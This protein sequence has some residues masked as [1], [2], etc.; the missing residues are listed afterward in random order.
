MPQRHVF[1]ALH[2]PEQRVSSLSKCSRTEGFTAR[3]MQTGNTRGE[4]IAEKCDNSLSLFS[5]L[6]RILRLIATPSATS[7][8]LLRYFWL[9]HFSSLREPWCA[10]PHIARREKRE[11]YTHWKVPNRQGRGH[12]SWPNTL[13]PD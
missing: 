6:E 8:D 4:F 12:A 2:V 1:N 5:S 7:A 10:R 11:P 9:W 3:R 13:F